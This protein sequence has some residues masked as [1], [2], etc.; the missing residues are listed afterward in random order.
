MKLIADN[1]LEWAAADGCTTYIQALELSGQNVPT[2]AR[3]RNLLNILARLP[4]AQPLSS[5]VMIVDI[6][7][8]ADRC[9]PKY[10]GQVAI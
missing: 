10:D 4:A 8:A 3:E 7:Q 9:R 5:T 6:S 1:Q 2:S